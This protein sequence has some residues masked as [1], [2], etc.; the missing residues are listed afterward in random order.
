MRIRKFVVLGFAALA[1]AFGG[2]KKE[3]LEPEPPK[4]ELGITPTEQTVRPVDGKLAISMTISGLE[5]TKYMTIEKVNSAGVQSVNYYPRVLEKEYTYNYVMLPTD[6]EEFCFRFTL[7]G[8]DGSR[9]ETAVA[10]VDNHKEETDPKYSRLVISNLQVVSR[11]TGKDDNGHDGLPAVK[12]TLNNNTH[13]RF[14]VGGTDLGIVWEISAGYYGLFFGD[15]FGS[16]FNPNFNAPGP[17]GGSWRSNVLLFSDDTTLEDG[18]TITG[19]ATDQ[20]GNARQIVYSA[21]NTSGN[22][23]YT[24]IPTSAV[25]ANGKDYVHYFNIKTWDGWV[26]NYS[27]MYRSTDGGGTWDRV[28]G[29]SWG[30]ESFFGQVGFCNIGDGYVYMVGT[31]SGRDSKPK[32]ARVPESG[33]ESQAQYEFWNG[34]EWIK[35]KEQ[36][37]S[38]LIDDIAGELSV[39]YLPEYEKWV[40]LYFN[41]PRYEITMRYADKITGPWSDAMTVASGQQYPQLYG[42]FIHPLSAQEDGKLYFI[43]SMW[44]PYNTY[45]MSVDVKGF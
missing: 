10:N 41:G 37:A 26:T 45:L 16:D 11:V 14:N 36:E 15:T 27:G 13:S 6:E 29:I 17:N 40:I 44:L 9:S 38:V 30:G 31:Q 24:S 22:G 4:E 28:T 7:V 33:I 12:Y 1:L 20:W 3:P 39:A 5:Q 21:H 32:L 35:G 42:S 25:H 43:M 19:A 8:T 23:D 34:A 2:C 18:L